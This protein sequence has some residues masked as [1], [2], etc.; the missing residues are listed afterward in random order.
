MGRN[1]S[2]NRLAVVRCDTGEDAVGFRAPVGTAGKV[3]RAFRTEQALVREVGDPCL[4]FGRALRRPRR[5]TGLAHGFRYLADFFA[6]PPAVLDDALE[7][8]GALLFP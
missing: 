4:A 8:V 7:K 1:R 6:A 2:F 3:L 5:Q